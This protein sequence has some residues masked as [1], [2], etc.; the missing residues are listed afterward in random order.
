MYSE[1]ELEY[2]VRQQ[3]Y[4][5]TQNVLRQ[6]DRQPA[7]AGMSQ[8]DPKAGQTAGQTSVLQSR[9]TGLSAGPGTGQPSGLYTSLPEGLPAD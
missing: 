1:H 4:P 8:S 9:T 6:V 3:V 2:Q 7:E 5:K